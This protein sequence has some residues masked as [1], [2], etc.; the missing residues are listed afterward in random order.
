MKFILSNHSINLSLCKKINRVQDIKYKVKQCTAVEA[1]LHTAS[2]QFLN[3]SPPYPLM[4]DFPSR[5]PAGTSC[6][7]AWS[8]SPLEHLEEE[9][10]TQPVD[11]PHLR[12][13]SVGKDERINYKLY[14][15]SKEHTRPIQFATQ[16]MHLLT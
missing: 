3:F 5:P 7:S 1:H 14:Q 12:A 10:S 11:L 13:L 15:Q 4:L 6:H 16:I 8:A 2:C 9:A